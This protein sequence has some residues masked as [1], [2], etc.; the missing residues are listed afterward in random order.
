MSW[1]HIL[2]ALGLP[3]G[4][5]L[6]AAWPLWRFKQFIVGNAVGAGVAFAIVVGL[7]GIAFVTQ[8]RENQQC[9]Q[10]LIACVSRVDAHMPFL[11]YAF[12]GIVDACAI[13]WVGLV[14][15]ERHAPK[16]WQ[17]VAPSDL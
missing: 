3:T 15:E 12:I 9:I 2:I 17:S 1:V 4:L 14:V 13:F 6:L 16:A 11:I 8:Q 7:I 5:G 10:G